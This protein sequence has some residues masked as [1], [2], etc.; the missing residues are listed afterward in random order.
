MKHREV[1]V[2]GQRLRVAVRPG[3]DGATPLLLCNGLGAPVEWLEP[4]VRE[5]DG[6]G[7]I[8]FDAPGTGGSPAPRFP[9]RFAGL[10]RLAARML[11]RLGYT[12][13]VD[14][15]GISWGGGVAQE[16]AHRFPQRCRRLVLAAT[17]SGVTMVPGDPRAAWSLTAPGK[18]R[19]RGGR[20][21]QLGDAPD[22]IVLGGGAGAV[23]SHGT[24]G[25]LGQLYALV[26][27]SS[28]HWLHR[29]RQ[30]T[31]ILSGRRD[32]LVPPINGRILERCIPHAQRVEFDAGHMFL[33]TRTRETA[34]AVR[35]FLA[36]DAVPAE[37]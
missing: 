27:W 25:M 22:E 12:G 1:E 30:P 17:S 5:L 2:D 28:L 31:L 33:N 19:A 23:T 15:M 18:S 26:G 7:V 37:R 16:F 8:A 20:F 4:L 14:V 10:A 11:D 21:A 3:P 32:R 6:L 35:R 36:D 24:R 29:L 9:L 13:P 34:E